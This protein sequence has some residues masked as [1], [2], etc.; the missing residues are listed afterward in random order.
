MSE[1]LHAFSEG[2]PPRMV[3][4]TEEPSDG[5]NSEA[6]FAAGKHHSGVRAPILG[7]EA[8]DV[9]QDDVDYAGIVFECSDIDY[10]SSTLSGA[11]L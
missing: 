8:R 4:R 10:K 7:V 6:K 3:R 9:N 11:R 5:R 1:N 2:I